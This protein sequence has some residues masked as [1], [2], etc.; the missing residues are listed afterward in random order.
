MGMHALLL[1]E[2]NH[3]LSQNQQLCA[4]LQAEIA[5]A[6]SKHPLLWLPP[7][8]DARPP[9]SHVEV[10][11]CFLHTACARQ[12]D[13]AHVMEAIPWSKQQLRILGRWGQD[14]LNS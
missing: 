3:V 7:K 5:A 12:L 11:G 14:V 13:R 2:H 10:E 1:A 9:A 8:T 6:F 4:H